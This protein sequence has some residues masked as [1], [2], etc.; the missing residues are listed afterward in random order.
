MIYLTMDNY[1]EIIEHCQKEYPKEV[2]G[3]LA[4]KVYTE[5]IRLSSAKDPVRRDGIVTKL[6]KMINISESP[7]TCYFMNPEE[8]L[9][10]FKEMRNLGIK[11]LGIY[12]SHSR[13]SAYPSQ[14]DCEMVFYPEASYII[15]SLKDFNNPDVRAFKIIE[16]K[17]DEEK[18]DMR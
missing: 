3:I 7:E 8:Q 18:I 13:S 11:M 9:K 16:G 14:R 1:Q 10:I 12:H 2:C 17:I 6:Y 4:G 15:V 5:D